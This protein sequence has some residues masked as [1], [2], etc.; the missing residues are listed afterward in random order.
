MKKNDL[1]DNHELQTYFNI[2]LEKILA[3]YGKSLMGWEEIMTEK[4]P[5]SG[6]DPFLER[7]Q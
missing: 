3:K 2:K 7:C 6:F 1:K 4:M 5:K